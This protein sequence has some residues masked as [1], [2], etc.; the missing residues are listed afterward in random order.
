MGVIKRQGLKGSIISIIGVVIG[1]IGS[2]FVYPLNRDMHGNILFWIAQ[3]TIIIPFLTF[4]FSGILTKFYPVY[5]N[6][7]REGFSY[8]SLKLISK[9]LIFTILGT[10]LIRFLSI[11]FEFKNIP[12]I[13]TNDIFNYTI[14]L[15]ILIIYTNIFKQFCINNLRI[16][17]PELIQSIGF[18]IVLIGTISLTLFYEISSQNIF[19]IIFTFYFLNLLFIVIYSIYLNKSDFIKVNIRDIDKDFK[20]DMY[21]FWL[22]VGL[23]SFGSLLIYNIDNYMIGTHLSKEEINIY[24]TFLVISGVIMIPMKSFVSIA[25]PIISESMHNNDYSK[26]NKLYKTLSTNLIIF[27]IF[28]FCIIWL[29]F[30]QLFDIMSEGHIYR[31]FKIIFLYIGLAKIFDLSTSINHYILNYSKW[32]K[33]N[34]VILLV[35][36]IINIYLNLLLVKSHGIIGIAI[37]T[38]ISIFLFNL[39]N[40]V[41]VYLK[42]KMQPFNLKNLIPLSIMIL[43]I[44]CSDY[45]DIS[46][47]FIITIG[48]KS[49][50][51]TI[52]YFAI[53]Y[54]TNISKDVN[55]LIENT[56]MKVKSLIS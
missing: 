23:N 44:F 12:S 38:T 32:Y 36:A 30:P 25:T 39:T 15:A 40:S 49:I 52:L 34:L 18:K 27:G 33:L 56:I 21:K 45:L 2:L 53:I 1:F 35:T 46:N 48:L 11:H 6:K 20:K 13:I 24:S 19:R 10:I 3:T 37:A 31:P 17:I 29:N 28:I 7:F 4:G 22:F 14:S 42:L 41:I 54:F 26:V 47:N 43:V 50:S 55:N 5:K 9:I 16:T 51:F 8:F